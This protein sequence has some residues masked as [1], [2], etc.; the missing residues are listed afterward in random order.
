MLKRFHVD[1][2]SKYSFLMEQLCE[3]LHRKPNHQ[4]TIEVLRKEMKMDEKS[5]KKLYHNGSNHVRVLQRNYK[6][7]YPNSK[8]A[9]SK[10]KSGKDKTVR[11]IQLTKMYVYNG[12]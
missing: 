1:R 6:D 7:I 3:I 11:F 10:T 2:R 5:F 9:D 8:E 4:A 12:G